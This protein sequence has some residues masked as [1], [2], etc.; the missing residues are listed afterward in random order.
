MDGLLLA[1]PRASTIGGGQDAFFALFETPPTWWLASRNVSRSQ[2][3]KDTKRRL[4]S[5]GSKAVLRCRQ[6]QLAVEAPPIRRVAVHN[7]RQ[8]QRKRLTDH[9]G[10]C[11]RGSTCTLW[12]LVFGFCHCPPWLWQPQHRERRGLVAETAEVPFCSNLLGGGR[13]AGAGGD[14]SSKCLVLLHP[15]GFNILPQTITPYVVRVTTATGG[16]FF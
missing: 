16:S 10:F 6:R 12:T 3:V 4:F 1:H 5:G 2:S 9:S 8:R 13:G 15:P 11:G 7:T 14:F